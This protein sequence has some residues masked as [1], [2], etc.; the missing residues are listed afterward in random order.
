MLGTI[1]GV[2]GELMNAGFDEKHEREKSN[3]LVGW[4]VSYG[5]SDLGAAYEIRAGRTFVSTKDGAGDRTIQL[6]DSSI[7][8]PH[9]AIRATQKHRVKVQDIFSDRGTFVRRS[10][11][12]DEQKIEGP[13]EVGHGDWIRIGDSVRFQVCLI[14]GPSR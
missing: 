5:L 9:L 14:D 4:L 11:S 13:V 1:F 12:H 2:K 7:A 6:D 10:D 3:R 8:S